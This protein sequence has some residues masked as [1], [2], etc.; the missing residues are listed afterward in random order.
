[1]KVDDFMAFFTVTGSAANQT[2]I[3]NGN[4]VSKVVD[5]GSYR[6][7]YQGSETNNYQTSETLQA[8]LAKLKA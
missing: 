3:I 6:V 4:N 1:M 8:I 7:I 2:A 5:M